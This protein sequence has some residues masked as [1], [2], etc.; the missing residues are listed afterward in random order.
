MGVIATWAIPWFHT[1]QVGFMLSL[2]VYLMAVAWTPLILAPL[3]EL[4]GRNQIYIY[5]GG[6]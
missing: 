6:L 4:F 5:V 2:L 3:S 1:D